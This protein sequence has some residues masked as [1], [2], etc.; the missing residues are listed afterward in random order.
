[1]NDFYNT[2]RLKIQKKFSGIFFKI[3]NLPKIV[4]YIIS[5]GS[6]AAVNILFLFLLTHYVGLWYLLS[7]IIAFML[8]FIVSFS[9]QKF[10]TFEDISTDAIHKQA[11]IYF[12]IITVNLLL[13]TLL[14]YFFVDFVKIQYILSQVITGGLIA[15]VS[16]FAYRKFVFKNSV[17]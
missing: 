9:L 15:C 4:R 7:S 14:M 5:G 2:L 8:A 11:G 17:S 13:N 6:A 3:K 10:W 16:F 1:M 12:F